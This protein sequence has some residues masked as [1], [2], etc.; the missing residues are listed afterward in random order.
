MDTLRD[1]VE[2][3]DGDSLTDLNVYMVNK[4]FNGKDLN[5]VDVN[6]G[7]PDYLLFDGHYLFDD[8]L[9]TI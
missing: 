4:P 9:D 2:F 8:K 1:F 6:F 7:L 5:G 3:K